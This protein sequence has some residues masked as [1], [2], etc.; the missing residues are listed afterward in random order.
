M[1]SMCFC[2][3]W[4]QPHVFLV[5]TKHFATHPPK[6]MGRGDSFNTTVPEPESPSPSAPS[7]ESLFRS[8]LWCRTD[9]AKI[10]PTHKH[11]RGL[12]AGEWVQTTGATARSPTPRFVP[13]QREDV[14]L[15]AGRAPGR[16]G[17][18]SG[19]RGWETNG[20][21]T[22]GTFHLHLCLVYASW[23]GMSHN[24]RQPIQDGRMAGWHP[25]PS[26]ERPS[27]TGTQN[28]NSVFCMVFSGHWMLLVSWKPAVA[29]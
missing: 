26:P 18:S 2:W 11:E 29:A 28:S 7:S 5:K 14:G 24:K 17:Q 22:P 25:A 6:E 4:V 9:L 1:Q 23:S 8:L 16:L 10:S 12:D 13:D 20:L 3:L 21:I 27:P 19:G 15:P